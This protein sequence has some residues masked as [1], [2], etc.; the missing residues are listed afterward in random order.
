MKY[1]NRTY[2]I[3]PAADL[4][5]E[6][7]DACIQSRLDTVRHSVDGTKCVLKWQGDTP[8]ALDGYPQL[9]HQAT[10]ALM[11]TPPWVHDIDE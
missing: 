4:T 7:V 5:Q 1:N 3:V 8:A 6:M 10:L 9:P 2:A 11:S